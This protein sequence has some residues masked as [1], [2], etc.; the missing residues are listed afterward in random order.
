MNIR[1]ICKNAIRPFLFA[2][3]I[4]AAGTAS[5]IPAAPTR[6]SPANGATVVQPFVESWSVVT[7]PNL[8]VAYNY[9]ISTTSAFASILSNGSTNGATQATISG[10]G[11]GTYV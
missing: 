10:L 3:G 7:D 2:L 9:E 8:I 6:L 1:N 5:A 4:F 11:T